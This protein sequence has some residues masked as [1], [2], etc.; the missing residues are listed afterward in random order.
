MSVING[1]NK[2]LSHRTESGCLIAQVK[3]RFDEK[4]CSQIQEKISDLLK[5]KLL[6]L[7]L[8]L[9]DV[10][11]IRSS[12]LRVILFLAKN[13]KDKDKNFFVVYSKSDEN[14]QVAQ[15]LKVSGF[16][17]I[18]SVCSTK[19]EAIEHCSKPSNR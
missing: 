15:I 3:D 6:H 14:H 16:T 9:N 19:E 2:Y 1:S 10:R 7:L 18:I 13:F 4:N 8:D 11:T 12:G 5:K 17:K